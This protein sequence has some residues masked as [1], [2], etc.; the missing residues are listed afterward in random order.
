MQTSILTMCAE[1]DFRLRAF[2]DYNDARQ[3]EYQQLIGAVT[4]VVSD[5]PDDSLESV[6][7][8]QTAAE[9]AAHE[10][11]S[12]MLQSSGFSE[13]D[14]IAFND[15]YATVGEVLE[16]AA[17]STLRD[18]NGV[19]ISD[20]ITLKDGLGN[21]SG[22]LDFNQMADEFK[23]S[24]HSSTALSAA[25]EAMEKAKDSVAD[26][27]TL[28]NNKMHSIFS[29][30][31]N[32][33]SNSAEY[34]KTNLLNA[35]NVSDFMASIIKTTNIEG[36]SDENDPA[37]TANS[38]FSQYAGASPLNAMISG[39]GKGLGIVAG[40]AVIA[41]KVVNNV[42]QSIWN[43][44]KSL[45]NKAKTAVNQTFVNP[46]DIEVLDKD[47]KGFTIDGWTIMM[48]SIYA[49]KEGYND[50]YYIAPDA[51]GNLMVRF[52]FDKDFYIAEQINAAVD[53]LNSRVGQW[54]KYMDAGSEILFRLREPVNAAIKQF[55]VSNREILYPL[56]QL[57]FY[58]RPRSLRAESVNTFFNDLGW[59]V[60]TTT[61]PVPVLGTTLKKYKDSL[62]RLM[63]SNSLH[64]G[65]N[66][67]ETEMY[68][69][70]YAGLRFTAMNL[71]AG[72]QEAI[73]YNPDTQT[74]KNWQ[75]A[76]EENA[77]VNPFGT[78]VGVYNWNQPMINSWMA[79]D[80]NAPDTDDAYKNQWITPW[81]SVNSIAASNA[82]FVQAATGA[83]PRNNSQFIFG[84]PYIDYYV[85]NVSEN[86]RTKTCVPIGLFM[87]NVLGL[88]FLNCL[89]R[90]VNPYT[91][92][93][94]PYRFGT[95]SWSPCTYKVKTDSQNLAV[96]ENII[97][98]AVIV[99]IVAAVAISA[100]VLIK[101]LSRALYFKKLQRTSALDS[102]MWDGKILTPAE[103][104]QYVRYNR[105]LNKSKMLSSGLQD[106]GSLFETHVSDTENMLVKNIASQV[107]VN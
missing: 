107:G 5:V 93:F 81:A 9:N 47:A 89:D 34:I 72:T 35:T 20:I 12:N 52:K 59:E 57:D 45:F 95:E 31:Y 65:T 16:S 51:N 49:K 63:N 75:Y 71:S 104:K 54:I 23:A 68:L 3:A 7:D 17:I 80:L 101:K 41:A 67:H 69:S 50:S 92:A 25:C 55:A 28:F 24:L 61:H 76:S 39:A 48:S 46:Y 40:A 100:V 70:F 85:D 15:G 14:R 98:T 60:D 64:P 97:T 1:D 32:D 103:Q 87:S 22:T 11:F 44:G 53:R 27:I 19:E 33:I 18:M 105:K 38:D 2:K 62:N 37:T 13:D 21:I 6:S 73:L 43:F 8:I 84:R 82:H 26:R 10:V 79:I 56:S 30:A 90:T 94:I 86:T 36:V 66:D 74:Q 29:N 96:A 102:A 83:Q 78:F 77:K 106:T 58:V 4:Q 88:L 99:L 91:W 42:V